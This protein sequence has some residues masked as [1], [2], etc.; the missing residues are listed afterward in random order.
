MKCTMNKITYLIFKI[1][2]GKITPGV[3]SPNLEQASCCD[4]EKLVLIQRRVLL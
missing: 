4:K 2:S 3:C 1:R